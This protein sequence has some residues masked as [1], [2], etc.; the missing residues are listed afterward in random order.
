M[1]QSVVVSSHSMDWDVQL[2]QFCSPDFSCFIFRCSDSLLVLDSLVRL[3]TGFLASVQN[4]F[5]VFSHPIHCNGQYIACQR[6]LSSF[7]ANIVNHFFFKYSYSRHRRHFPHTS[8]PLIFDAYWQL[9]FNWLLPFRTIVERIPSSGLYTSFNTNF[10]S[11][12]NESRE[13]GSMD[14]LWHLSSILRSICHILLAVIKI[15]KYTYA[16]RVDKRLIYFNL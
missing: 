6:T 11:V 14:F 4:V 16:R 5:V 10:S 15:L 8:I 9:G 12:H 3:S 1:G 7:V 13:G 2:P